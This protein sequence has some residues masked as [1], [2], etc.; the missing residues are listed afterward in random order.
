MLNH[1]GY[2]FQFCR[3][4]DRPQSS[5]GHGCV[6]VVTQPVEA[7]TR[8]APGFHGGDC[9]LPAATGLL[10][11]EELTG[12][13]INEDSVAVHSRRRC[14]DGWGDA[15]CGTFTFSGCPTFGYA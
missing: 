10:H 2:T 4:H 14:P 8:R 5:V 1:M 12:L 9:G 7:Q 15:G 13:G 6:E 3:C 11:E